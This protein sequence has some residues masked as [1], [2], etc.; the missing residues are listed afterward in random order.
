MW[1]HTKKVKKR[2]SF[3]KRGLATTVQPQPDFSRTCSFCEVL[4]INEDCLNTKFHLNRWSRFWN[5]G[6]KHKKCPQNGFFPYLWPPKIFFQKSG[7][8][9]FVPLC[10]P[11]FMQKIKKTYERSLRY[12]KM[13]RPT[14]RPTDKGDY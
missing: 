13:D 3:K 8:V 2:P 14:D 5:I 4:G 6:K 9:T 11:N 12:L 1:Y 7:S 10:C